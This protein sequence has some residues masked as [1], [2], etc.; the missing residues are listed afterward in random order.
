MTWFWRSYVQTDLKIRFGSNFDADTR[1]PRSL[2]INFHKFVLIFIVCTLSSLS[3]LF[4]LSMVQRD[5]LIVQRDL[6]SHR[7]RYA[8]LRCCARRRS[9]SLYSTHAQV[10][11]VAPCFAGPLGVCLRSWVWVSICVFVRHSC[12]SLRSSRRIN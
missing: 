7:T 10:S 12:R 9:N 11:A 1:L 6:L 3:L 2:L 4:P 8:D 5:L